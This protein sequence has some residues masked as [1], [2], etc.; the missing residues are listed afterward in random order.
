[1]TSAEAYFN[2]GISPLFFSFEMEGEKLAQRWDAYAAKISYRA[3]KRGQ[4][5]PEDYDK[6]MR[7]AEAASASKFEK[8][9]VVIDNE[10]R[11]TADF[12]YGQIEK[13]RPGISVVDT[14]DEVR[15]P[16]H[17]KGVWEQQDFVARE[18]KGIARSTRRPL[19][20]V[21]QSGRGAAEEGATLGNI[22]SSITIGRKAD[23]AL[24]IHST[25]EQKKMK[26]VEFRL[27][28][29]RD[30]EGE[31]S[32]WTKYWDKGSGEIRPWTAQDNIAAKPQPQG[33]TPS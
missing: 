21:A 11:P 20:A 1:M 32:S 31:G 27:L 30:D 17:L 14:L 29:N 26:M 10:R 22:A 3:M 12:I 7:V 23:I 2:K 4:L 8:D 13:W 15:S 33:A 24:G 19:I 5:Q 16:A 18:L 9:I 6:W 25:P 28:K